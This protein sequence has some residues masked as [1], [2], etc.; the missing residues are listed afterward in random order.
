M[1]WFHWD[2]F[3]FNMRTQFS[4]STNYN[5]FRL[6]I[7]HSKHLRYNSTLYKSNR[8]DNLRFFREISSETINNDFSI[9]EAEKKINLL[10]PWAL[11]PKE[12]VSLSLSSVI[13]IVFLI[14]CRG[15]N[16]WN[17]HFVVIFLILRKNWVSHICVYINI[18]KRVW[19]SSGWFRQT[20]INVSPY[21]KI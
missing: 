6:I 3:F 5:M 10:R 14:I 16:Y 13:F 8:L 1:Q 21:K 7:G 9:K 12:L 17:T 15:N 4:I 18:A 20:K 19:R 11:I 2:S